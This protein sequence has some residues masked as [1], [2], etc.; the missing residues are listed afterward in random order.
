VGK[1]GNNDRPAADR[2]ENQ[3]TRIVGIE[4]VLRDYNDA[5]VVET[6]IAGGKVDT[7]SMFDDQRTG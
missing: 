2:T 4:F 7:S 3:V 1:V 6:V 5:N